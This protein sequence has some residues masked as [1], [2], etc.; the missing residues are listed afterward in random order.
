MNGDALVIIKGLKNSLKILQWGYTDH[1]IN[2]LFVHKNILKNFYLIYTKFDKYFL[3]LQ[4]FCDKE[5]QKI[6]KLLIITKIF[7]NN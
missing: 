6:Y 2:L 5:N 7:N 1:P 4:K 3:I